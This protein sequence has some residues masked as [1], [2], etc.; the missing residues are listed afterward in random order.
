MSLKATRG[1]RDTDTSHHFIGPIEVI[2]A[3]LIVDQVA[4]EHNRHGAPIFECPR[5]VGEARHS[6]KVKDQVRVLAGIPF[7]KLGVGRSE[8]GA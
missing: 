1:R 8:I 4:S 7:Q 6:A 2:A 5:S 3:C